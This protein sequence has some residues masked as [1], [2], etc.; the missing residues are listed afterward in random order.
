MKK[1]IITAVIALTSMALPAQVNASEIKKGDTLEISNP[2]GSSY[3]HIHFPKDNLIIKRGGINNDASVIGKKVVVTEIITEETGTK[4][5]ISPT[6][7]S[8]FYNALRS[9]TVD[10]EAALKEGEIK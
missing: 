4:V 6:D 9:V 8:R 5:R 7:N 2:S 1:T 10:I 3:Q